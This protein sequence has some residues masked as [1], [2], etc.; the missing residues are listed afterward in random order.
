MA[1]IDPTVHGVVAL[2]ERPKLTI[3]FASRSTRGDRGYTLADFQD[4]RQSPRTAYE[5]NAVPIEFRHIYERG[6]VRR[7]ARVVP[8]A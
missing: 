2:P 3:R 7:D 8:H 4:A 1:D 6:V 5:G